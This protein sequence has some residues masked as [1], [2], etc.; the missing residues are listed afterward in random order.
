MQRLLTRP[1][2]R[3][4][5]LF[6]VTLS[7][8]LFAGC[9]ERNDLYYALPNGYAVARNNGNSIDIIYNENWSDQI[10]EE[11]SGI[12]VVDNYYIRAF[13]HDDVF[14]GL[15]GVHTEKSYA[16]DEEKE[17]GP[18][19][20]Y[21][22]DS[23]TGTCFGPFETMDELASKCEALGFNTLGPWYESKDYPLKW[24]SYYGL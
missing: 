1:N 14:I 8:L 15:E 2:G 9:L 23:I 13:C 5:L 20:Y 19:S 12:I 21:L 18:S 24:K 10:G 6:V 7:M 16:T 11:W 3:V 22:I 17:N 4:N